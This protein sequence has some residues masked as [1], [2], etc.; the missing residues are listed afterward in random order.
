M[1]AGMFPGTCLAEMRPG[2]AWLDALNRVAPPAGVRCVA[3]WSGTTR[4]SSPQL[5][6]RWDGAEDV[7]FVGIAH[8]ALL[9]DAGVRTCVAELLAKR[10]AD[11][12]EESPTRR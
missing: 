10:E 7:E 6:A 9:A 1:L 5:N 4:W 8:N 11:A 12:D 3:L 2:S